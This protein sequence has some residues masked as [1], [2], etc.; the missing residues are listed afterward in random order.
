M[1]PQGVQQVA[2]ELL[3]TIPEI[4]APSQVLEGPLYREMTQLRRLRELAKNQSSKISP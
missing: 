1:T 4:M 3:D 2:Q